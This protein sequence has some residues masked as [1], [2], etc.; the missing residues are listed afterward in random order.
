MDSSDLVKLINKCTDNEC[1]KAVSQNY[2][3]SE[4]FSNL[5][6]VIFVCLSLFIIF[7]YSI[8]YFK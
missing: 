4:I 7:K 8:K 3:L 6:I 5:M 2:M 1:V